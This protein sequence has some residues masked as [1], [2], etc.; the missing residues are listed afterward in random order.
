MH[1]IV[2]R[3]L[4]YPDA[5]TAAC[6]SATGCGCANYKYRLINSCNICGSPSEPI[7]T[8]VQ[9]RIPYLSIGKNK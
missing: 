9:N 7:N 8:D 5:A 6:N 2:N 4:M 1:L 3:Q